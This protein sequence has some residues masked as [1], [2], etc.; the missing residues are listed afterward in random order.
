MLI[1]GLRRA[2]RDLSREKLVDELESLRGFAT[3]S[4]PPLTYG[5]ARRLG[6]RGAYIVRLDPREKRFIPEG[7]WIEV[8]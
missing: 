4:I 5:A 1:E 6:A 8:E 3:G 7:K 2:G